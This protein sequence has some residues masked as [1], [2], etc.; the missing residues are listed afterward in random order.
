MIE[1]IPIVGIISFWVGVIAVLFIALIFGLQRRKFLNKEIMLAIEKGIDIPFPQPKER[2]YNRLGL[3]FSLV[4]IVF[5][6][7]MWVS[8]G[9]IGFLWGLLPVGLGIAFLLIARSEKK[10]D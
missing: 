7:A 8:A 6:I 4:G 5:A 1:I 2:N 10:Q 9:L 3:I